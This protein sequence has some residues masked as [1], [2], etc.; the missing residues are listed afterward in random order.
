MCL[1]LH[2]DFR[3]LFYPLE[4]SELNKGSIPWLTLTNVL[5][6]TDQETLGV[7][8]AECKLTDWLCGLGQVP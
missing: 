3:L 1:S 4:A 5:T 7:L 6:P 8:R 2:L